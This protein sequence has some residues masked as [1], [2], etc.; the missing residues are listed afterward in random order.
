LTANLFCR[1]EGRI[2]NV[3]TGIMAPQDAAQD[4]CSFWSVFGANQ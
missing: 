4:L 3:N 2:Q 1:L